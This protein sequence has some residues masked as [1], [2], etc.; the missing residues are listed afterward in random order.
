MYTRYRIQCWLSQYVPQYCLLC[1]QANHSTLCASCQTSIPRF[2]HAQLYYNLMRWPKMIEAL[3]PNMLAHLHAISDYEYPISHWLK[4]LKFEQKLIYAEVL[5]NLFV[6]S[7]S[8]RPGAMPQALIPAPL[9]TSRYVKRQFNQA[10][11]L[12]QSI[13]YRLHIPI[14]DGVLFR[15]HQTKAQSQLNREQRLSNVHNAFIAD[16][17]S[18]PLS[19]IA[20]VDDVITTGSTMQSMLDA[21][22]QS[23][24]NLTVEVW[25]IAVALSS[26][27][28]IR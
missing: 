21:F 16:P 13:G 18:S 7:I 3:R 27:N 24:P 12:A 6:T 8:K 22:K 1:R 5:A 23:N 20:I 28:E 10:R 26:L 15:Q 11:V 2:N 25:S 9:H 17:V 19:H 14:L 4:Q